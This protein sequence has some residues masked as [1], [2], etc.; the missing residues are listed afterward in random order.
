[1][2]LNLRLPDDYKEEITVV[3]LF[4]IVLNVFFLRSAWVVLPIMPQLLLSYLILCNTELIKERL[5]GVLERMEDK[6]NVRSDSVG[7][8]VS[9]DSVLRRRLL[10]VHIGSDSS[11]GIPVGINV[12]N[13]T[14]IACYA[15]SGGGKTTI[16]YALLYDVVSLYD[17]RRVTVAIA[18][19]KRY[20]F[21]IFGKIPHLFA[22]IGAG[23]TE[24]LRLLRRIDRELVEREKLFAKI[25]QDRLCENLRDYHRIAYE[26][27][28]P[29]PPIPYLLM[30]VDEVQ[31][32]AANEE[33]TAILT[34]LAKK[35]RAL[36]IRLV[37][38]TQ[39]PTTAGL[40][41]EIQSQLETR[42]VGYM[43][44]SQEYSVARVPPEVYETMKAKPGRFMMHYLGKWTHVQVDRIPVEQLEAML[45]HVSRGRDKLEWSNKHA[46]V[47]DNGSRRIVGQ[48]LTQTEKQQRV[49]EWMVDIESDDRP[50]ADELMSAFDVSQATAY[51]YLDR[52]WPVALERRAEIN[53]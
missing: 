41:H 11:E 6:F 1:M 38:A 13:S 14:H 9:G 47:S 22:P 34:R 20:S 26:L 36:G 25:P 40:S 12:G 51:R 24:S 42:F 18:D 28:L 29:L 17:P 4:I 31:E 48:G 16:L 35:G 23:V 44:S 45:R 27:S 33:A 39:R 3:F 5:S 8:D 37:L 43:S 32:V 53:E 10:D 46:R 50:S 15:Q 21:T 52:L 7:P 19:P 49:I 30:I 2:K